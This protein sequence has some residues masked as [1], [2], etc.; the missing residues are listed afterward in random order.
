MPSLLRQLVEFESGVQYQVLAKGREEFSYLPGRIPILISA[1][2]GAVHMRG[3][4]PKQEDEYTSG[5]ARVVG[6]FSN[7]HVI[8]SHHM[9]RTD[10]NWY[11]NVP[12]KQRLQQI[13]EEEEIRFVLDIHGVAEHRTFGIAIG[14]MRGESCP[15]H[16]GIIIQHLSSHGFK[17]DAQEPLRRVDVDHAFTAVGLRGQ[18]TITRFVWQ[19]HRVP[20]AQFELHPLL[21]I[22][23]RR[24][25][26]TERQPFQGNPEMIEAAIRAFVSLVKALAK[27]VPA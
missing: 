21:R 22:V 19:K 20:V 14:T 7:A 27:P 11:P 17:G 9:S 10:P 13:L 16:L 6:E 24:P 23:E 12:Y 5:F 25:D 4:R 2:H 26:A 3:G 1:P 8:Y 18:E 15:R